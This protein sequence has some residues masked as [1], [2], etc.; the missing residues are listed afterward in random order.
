MD[1]DPT[2]PI[3]NPGIRLIGRLI[4][5]LNVSLDG[6]VEAP[7]GSLDWASLRS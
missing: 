6:Y 5:S 2:D 4:Y 7:D 3:E 1:H